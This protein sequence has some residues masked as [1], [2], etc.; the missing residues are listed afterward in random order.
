M[1]WALFLISCRGDV[2][3]VSSA[4]EVPEA[5]ARLQRRVE[6]EVPVLTREVDDALVVFVAPTEWSATQIDRQ[7]VGRGISHEWAS[8]G[9]SFDPSRYLGEVRLKVR[10]VP[11]PPLLVNPFDGSSKPLACK[12]GQIV[13]PF[14][15]GP[16]ALVVFADGNSSVVAEEPGLREVAALEGD[17]DVEL[18]PTLDN[19]GETSLGL[20]PLRVTIVAAVGS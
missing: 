9:Y 12:D 18:I 15:H 14:D 10:D 4:S 5:L 3:M 13:V 6:A 2:V 8:V 11:G 20:L 17:W 19:T 1:L 16:A 7:P